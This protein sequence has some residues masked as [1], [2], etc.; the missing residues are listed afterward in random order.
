M[1]IIHRGT[2]PAERMYRSTCGCCKSVFEYKASEATRVSD[3]RDGTYLWFKCQVCGERV[4]Q[5]VARYIDPSS[6]SIS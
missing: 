3:Y 2:P 4:T 6:M 1:N 5:D